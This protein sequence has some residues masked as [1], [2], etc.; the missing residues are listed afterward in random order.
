MIPKQVILSINKN[1]IDIQKGNYSTWQLNNS[2]RDEFEKAEN[3]KGPF[4]LT[5]KGL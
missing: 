1:N 4:F 3:E 2:R 5:G